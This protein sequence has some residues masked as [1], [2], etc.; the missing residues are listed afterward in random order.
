MDG[1]APMI[2]P[3]SVRRSTPGSFSGNF[4]RQCRFVQATCK[5]ARIAQ[6]SK[7][8]TA[9]EATALLKNDWACLDSNQGPRDYESPALTAVL[10]A[11]SFKNSALRIAAPPRWCPFKLLSSNEGVGRTKFTAPRLLQPS[12]LFCIAANRWRVRCAVE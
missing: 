10:Q 4:S 11:R 5:T 3:T 12:V 8:I 9:P 6:H 1:E 2:G 7:R